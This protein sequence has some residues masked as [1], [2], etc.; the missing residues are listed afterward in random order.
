MLHSPGAQ[1]KMSVAN[2][3]YAAYTWVSL[4]VEVLMSR[5]LP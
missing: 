5:A 4:G 3:S 1:Q 2:P